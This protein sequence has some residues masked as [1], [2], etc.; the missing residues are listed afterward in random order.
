V[1][2]IIV[3]GPPGAGKSTLAA[4]IAT[5][6][7][8]PHVEL[9]SLW[10]DEAWTEAGPDRFRERLASRLGTAWV[11]D[12]NYF[13]NGS[14][15]HIWPSADTVVWLD[16]PRRITFSRVVWRSA[17]RVVRRTELW[18]GNRETVRD[19]VARD[20]VLWFSWRAHP[21]YGRRYEVVQHDPDLAS[22]TWVRLRSSGEV[23]RW[24][25]S[26]THRSSAA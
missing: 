21:D 18:N 3:V 17:N 12:G 1:E 25:D 7:G 11:V 9:D 24:R 20:S 19:V 10:W 15:E 8:Y 22:L 13:D 14:R 4:S 16:L 6:L 5:A 26:I 2:R 23:R